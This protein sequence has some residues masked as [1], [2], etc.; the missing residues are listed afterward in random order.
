VD[1]GAVARFEA[2]AA[3]EGRRLHGLAYLLT[4]DWH[5]AED[6]V[7]NALSRIYMAWPKVQR[8]NDPAAYARRVL[9]N[10]IRSA[11]RKRRV[12]TTPVELPETASADGAQERADRDALRRMLVALPVRQRTVIVLRFFDDRTEADVADLLGISVGTVKSQTAKALARL[13]SL[14]PA[15]LTP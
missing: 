13:R 14:V 5:D 12:D 15:E 6:A 3:A 11:R 10:T 2:F 1:P 4:G 8:A 9:V 7:Q